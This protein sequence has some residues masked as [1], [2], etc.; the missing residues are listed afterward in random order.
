VFENQTFRFYGV[1]AERWAQ[2]AFWLDYFT[3]DNIPNNALTLLEQSNSTVLSSFK[4]V[5]HFEVG[6]YGTYTPVFHDEITTRIVGPSWRNI[7]DSTILDV[8]ADSEEGR[9][10]YFPGEPDTQQFIIVNL[11]YAHAC[12]NTT[13]VSKFYIKINPEAN[14]TEVMR[15]LWDIAPNSFEKIES[16][17]EFIDAV[18]ESRTGQTIFG[19]YTL[20]VL[21][22]IIYLTF[23]ITI[24]AMVRTRNLQ[25][26]F[27][28]LRALGTEKKDIITSVL[29]DTI[30]GL[31]LSSLIGSLIG[32]MLTTL[33]LSVPLVYLGSLITVDWSRLP[34]LLAIPVPLL[35]FLMI[36]SLL[37]SLIAT[38]LVTER[39]LRGNIAEQIAVE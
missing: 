2:T 21:F 28:V 34:V 5:S 27:S 39:S 4:P 13:R 32:L 1:Q 36:S 38:Y 35:M 22:S 29:A 37:F 11:D 17:L 12:L 18:L 33:M 30:I 8:M 31:F 9:R 25:R 7:T 19:V 10:T 23:G 6:A 15:D 24:V 14:Y 26:Q 16:P 3:L 20:N